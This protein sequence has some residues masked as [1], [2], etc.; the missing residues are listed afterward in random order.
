M[1]IVGSVIRGS[2]SIG[3]V[4]NA[5]EERAALFLRPIA[6]GAATDEMFKKVGDATA[7][8]LLFVHTAGADKHLDRDDG[9]GMRLLNQHGE[10]M[11]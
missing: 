3:V 5:F 6:R 11:I 1:N 4:A 2:V 8:I 10:A 9:V 7:E